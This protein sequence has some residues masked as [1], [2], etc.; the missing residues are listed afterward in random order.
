M[1]LL[2]YDIQKI[3]NAQFFLHN[4]V[5]ITNVHSCIAIYQRL[6]SYISNLYYSIIL[7]MHINKMMASNVTYSSLKL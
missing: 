3:Q 6:T 5:I 7:C 4:K 2:M 1:Y